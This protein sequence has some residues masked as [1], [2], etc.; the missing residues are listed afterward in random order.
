MEEQLNNLE[1]RIE[2][3]EKTPHIKKQTVNNNLLVVLYF[4]FWLTIILAFSYAVFILNYS[5]WI[6]LIPVLFAGE[7]KI[8][9]K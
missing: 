8:K 7:L 3:L 9:N 5:V 1:K 6:L 4:L 2:I